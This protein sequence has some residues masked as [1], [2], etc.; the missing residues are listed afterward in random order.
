MEQHVECPV[1]VLLADCRKWN[2]LSENTCWIDTGSIS[3]VTRWSLGEHNLTGN[4]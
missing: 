4:I 1:E 2:A 3:A